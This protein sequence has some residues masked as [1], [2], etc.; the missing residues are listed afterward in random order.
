MDHSI[1]DD[2]EHSHAPNAHDRTADDAPN[3]QSSNHAEQAPDIPHEG[4]TEAAAPAPHEAQ[5]EGRASADLSATSVRIPITQI[6]PDPNQPRTHFD[7]LE[8]KWL[9]YSIEKNGVLQPIL[10]RPIAEDQYVI[11]AGERRYRGARE[12][13]L[14]AV[15]A[16]I[17]TGDEGDNVDEHTVRKLALI[18]NIQRQELNEFDSTIAILDHLREAFGF[19]S[20]DEVASFL[21][22]MR[23]TASDKPGNERERAIKETFKE[24]GKNWRSFTNNQLL[25][26]SFH[27]DLQEQI[28]KGNLEY[29]K[30]RVLNRIEDAEFRKHLMWRAIGEPLT[31]AEIEREIAELSGSNEPDDEDDGRRTNLMFTMTRVRKLYGR[32]KRKLAPEQVDEI[33]GALERLNALLEQAEQPAEPQ[34]SAANGPSDMETEA[35]A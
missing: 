29:S 9:A 19:D 26:L 32:V 3:Q 21:R 4:S 14:E 17:V 31:R 18:E 2:M 35:A 30:A 34:E 12:A 25:I 10:V 27:P 8:L 28:R 11:V 23:R 1:T 24:L 22:R 6:S 13:G 15:P 20:R 16:V 33:E 7:E 5:E